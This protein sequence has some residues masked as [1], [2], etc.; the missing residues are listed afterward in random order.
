MTDTTA[1]DRVADTPLIPREMLFGNPTRSGGKISPDGN[2]VSWMAPWEGVMNVFLAPTDD[3]DNSRRMT[4]AKDRPIPQ[5]FW[6]P[7]SQSLLY[8]RD[9]EGDENFL[10]YTVPVTAREGAEETCLTPFEDTRVQ[11]VGGSETIKDKLLVGLNNRDPRFHDVHLL[12]LNS[13]ELELV[14][15]NNEWAGFEADDSLTL[16]WAVRQNAAGGTD[17]HEIVDGVV[18]EEP[19]ETTGLDDA[20]TTGMAGYTTDGSTLY[21]LDSRGRDTAALFAEDTATGERKLIAEHDKADIGGTM[22]EPKTG[23]VQAWSATYLRTEHHPIDPEIGEALAWLRER[24]DG[25]F[26]VQ[27]RTDDDRRWLVWNDPLT[28]P[29]VSYLFDRDAMTLT[30]F[31]VTKPELEGAPLQPMHP[32]E[33][34]ARDGLTLPSYLTLPPQSDLDGDGVPSAPVPMVLY[35][36]GG[37]WA[38]DGYGYNRTHQWL[39]NRGYAVLSVNFRGSTGFGKGFTSAG[40]KE[41]A[42]KMHDDLLDA[43]EWAVEQGVA[44]R[45]KVAIMGGSYGGYAT[46]VGLA[47][48]P[49]VFA[50]GVDIVG[51]S[52][53]ETLLETIPP[54]WEPLIKQ[55][56][57]RMG[58]PTTPEGLQKLKDISPLYRAK[59]ITRPLLIGQGANDPRVKQAESDQIVEAMERDGV[60]VTYV[61]FPDE[62]H[63]FHRPENNIAFNAIA[64]NFLA[65]VIGGRAEPVG[66]VLGA[67][68]AEIRTGREHVGL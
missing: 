60:P 29:I 62:G 15:E 57:E 67:S 36:H 63:G 5:Y 43:V 20:L 1:A 38:R 61:L 13:G 37:P 44:E 22:R 7:D 14:F 3:P 11:V 27:S 12:D 52:N 55:F 66:D 26:G 65:E 58:D 24:L 51:P 32:V 28:A 39:A 48:T 49:N 21:W 47:F 10:L 59:D 50:C 4:S 40:D 16:R 25:D 45:D 30:Q 34:P 35:V 23:V 19:R 9:K 64:E 41:W 68:T 42:G 8:V 56:H 2:W 31:Y 33:I 54:Y 18:A 17:M 46:L 53:L 6:A